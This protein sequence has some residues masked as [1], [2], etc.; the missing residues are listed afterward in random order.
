MA[1]LAYP[2][3]AQIPTA[4]DRAAGRM[5]ITRLRTLPSPVLVLRHPWY[6]TETS[7]GSFAQAE[8]IGDV[9]RSGATRG[10]RLLYP[11]PG[12]RAGRRP[13]PGRGT[14]RQL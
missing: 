10:A 9:L 13:D 1:L 8:A 2:L 4:A 12:R 7:G 5:L 3:G 14:R 11:L 6:A